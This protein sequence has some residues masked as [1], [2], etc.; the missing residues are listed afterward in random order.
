MANYIVNISAKTPFGWKLVAQSTNLELIRHVVTA[1]RDNRR[2]EADAEDVI[3]DA[4]FLAEIDQIIAC[5]TAEMRGNA[6]A[7]F[8]EEDQ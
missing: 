7:L 6:A 4:D 3:Y 1:L 8:P 5:L 2:L